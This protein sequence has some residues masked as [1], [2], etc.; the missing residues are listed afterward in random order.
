MGQNG[1]G[2]AVAALLRETLLT[3]GSRAV[4]TVTSTSMEP[5]LR[6]GDRITIEGTEP[7]RLR[8]G[9][10]VVYE[11]PLAGLV[12]HRLMW[13]VPPIGIPRVAFTKGDA[14]LY[15]DRPFAVRG[16]LGRV[17]GIERVD[18]SHR[19][20]RKLSGWTGYANWLRAAVAWGWR[21]SMAGM[22]RK[23]LTRREKR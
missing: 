17:V 10:I 23:A 22:G 19:S 8:R 14:L 9:D 16:I 21:S 7:S 1:R 15:L 11:S 13:R 12:V 3:G 4:A 5:T 20:R 18:G 6:Q 2:Q